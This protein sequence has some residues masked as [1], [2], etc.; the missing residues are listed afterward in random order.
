MD[1]YILQGNK[2]KSLSSKYEQ[3]FIDIDKEYNQ[4]QYD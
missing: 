1:S 4:K 3:K 2:S